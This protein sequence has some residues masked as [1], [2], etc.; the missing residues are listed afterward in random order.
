MLGLARFIEIHE[1]GR[2]ALFDFTRFSS[3]TSLAVLVLSGTSALAQAGHTAAPEKPAHPA[4][5]GLQSPPSPNT[6]LDGTPVKLR[7]GETISSSAARTGQQVP[8]EVV[9]DV[10]LNG[11]TILAKGA[12]ALATVVDAEHK[13]SMGR[14]GKLDLNVDSVRL[15]DNEKVQLRATAG[16][17]AGG[18]VG[19]M[20]GAMVATSIVFFPAAPLFLF[21]HGKDI[22]LPKGLETTAFVDGDMKINL[23]TI[24]TSGSLAG[25]SLAG[26]SG[27][28]AMSQVS[29]DA[30]APNCDISVDGAFAGNTPSELS[31]STG[32]HEIKVHKEGFGDWTRTLALSGASVHVHAELQAETAAK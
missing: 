10:Q 2:P 15:L 13:K 23:D 26:G 4:A 1:I 6:L 9:E 16:G 25:G 31:L 18:H 30:S 20:T 27:A 17:K 5:Q 7:L 11:V 28:V 22:T 29:I 32:K 12:V 14:G 19:A 24:A 21:I 8:F 3:L